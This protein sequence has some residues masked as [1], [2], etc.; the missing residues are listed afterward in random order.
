MV[1]GL[2]FNRGR[3]WREFTGD[4]VH[5][6]PGPS[7]AGHDRTHHWMLCF[8]EMLRRMFAGRRIATAHMAAGHALAQ[9][10]PRGA[11]FQAFFA[12]DWHARTRKVRSGE[13]LKMFAW[14]AHTFSPLNLGL[15][16]F[17]FASNCSMV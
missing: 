12:G 7:L 10:H 4:F 17:R 8:V 14:L 6:A 3:G 15:D 16:G 1:P 9:R 11:F 13:V 5:V 2:L